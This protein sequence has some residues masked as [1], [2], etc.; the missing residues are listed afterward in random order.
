MADSPGTA[1][2]KPSKKELET[3]Y[4]AIMEG[5]EIPTVG[6]PEVISRQIMERILNAET[7]EDAFQAQSLPAW[8]DTLMNVP[9]FVRDIRLNPSKYKESGS[10]VYAVVDVQP[11][12]TETG[13]MEETRTV[14][15]GGRNVLMQLVKMLEKGW[16]DKPVQLI[17]RDT[18]EGYEALWL[19]S[20]EAPF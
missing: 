2:E 16:S 15:I 20:V 4:A 18:T 3:A 17:S 11:F 9:V 5:K 1:L 8:R 10:S 7:F 13:E 6:D 12:S 19:E 14:A